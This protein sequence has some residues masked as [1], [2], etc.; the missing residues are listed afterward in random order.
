MKDDD[1]AA[2]YYEMY[3]Q[4]EVEEDRLDQRHEGYSEAYFFLAQYYIEKKVKIHSE[5]VLKFCL[6]TSEEP[7]LFAS[8]C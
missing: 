4:A 3:V 5:V 6:Q 1:K 7:P 2:K 8:F